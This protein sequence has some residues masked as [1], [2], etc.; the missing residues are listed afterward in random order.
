MLDPELEYV[1]GIHFEV[2][3][4]FYINAISR[5]ELDKAIQE[6]Q[7]PFWYLHH[8]EGFSSRL[9]QLQSEKDVITFINIHRSHEY[10]VT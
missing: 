2:K 7:T 4:S 3:N 6:Y 5:I 1:R 9:R 10:A 8:D